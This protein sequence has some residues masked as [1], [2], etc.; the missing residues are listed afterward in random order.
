M[1]LINNKKE[2]IQKYN[3]NIKMRILKARKNM[4][5]YKID[6]KILIY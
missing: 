4:I 5:L 2:I 1:G 6:K 3:F